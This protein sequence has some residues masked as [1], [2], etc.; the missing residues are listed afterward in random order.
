MEDVKDAITG[1]DD[2]DVD[3]RSIPMQPVSSAH[4]DW[5]DRPFKNFQ[6]ASSHNSYLHS[7]QFLSSAGTRG[8]KQAMN[9]GARMV[10]LDVYARNIHAGD[11]EPVVAHGEVVNDLHLKVTSACPFEEFIKCIAEEAWANTDDPFFLCIENVTAGENETGDRMADA[12]QQHMPEERLLPHEM[13]L[14]ETPFRDLLGKLIIINGRD[15]GGR[16]EQ[17]W[18]VDFDRM[19]GFSNTDMADG[20]DVLDVNNICR[21]YP[22]GNMSGLMSNNFDPE[23][24]LGKASF[25]ALNYQTH[26]ENLEKAINHFEGCSFKLKDD[27]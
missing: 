9:K 15:C 2:V 23:P 3:E 6:V 26:D 24:F 18:T 4:E 8:V 13:N 20:P 5:L 14:H 27:C 22:S 7:L 21:V 25:V 1:E 10:E 16:W 19:G 17:Q 11:F 12:V